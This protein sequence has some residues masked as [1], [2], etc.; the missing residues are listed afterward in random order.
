MSQRGSGYE[1]KESIR[2]GGVTSVLIEHLSRPPRSC[3]GTGAGPFYRHAR[4]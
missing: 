3:M 1:R 4:G 2:L